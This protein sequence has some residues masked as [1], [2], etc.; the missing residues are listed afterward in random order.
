[1]YVLYILYIHTIRIPRI[2]RITSCDL[3]CDL[4]YYFLSHGSIGSIV[5]RAT[6]INS[7]SSALSSCDTC[8]IRSVTILSLSEIIL[9]CSYCVKKGLVYIAIAAPSS[10]QPSSCSKCTRLNT[11]SSYNVRLVSNTKYIYTYRISL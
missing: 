8:L 5:A 2:L 4:V 9:L 6:S 1:M 7:S 11:R 3:L 10:R